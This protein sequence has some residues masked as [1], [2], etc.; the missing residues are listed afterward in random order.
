MAFNITD[1]ARITM[2]GQSVAPAIWSYG[3]ADTFAT[4]VASA[5]FNDVAANLNIGDWI[6]IKASDSNLAVGV[7]AVTPNVTVSVISNFGTAL[8]SGN[9]LVGNAGNIA[10]SV[11]MSGDATMDNAGALTVGK[12]L[13]GGNAAN[14]AV[15]SVLGA[16]PVLHAVAVTGGSTA[17]YNVT[18][19]NKT[20]VTDAWVQ[21]NGLGTASD[22]ITV[23]STASAITN[24]MDINVADTTIVRA[25]TIDDATAAIPAGGVLRVNQVDGGG[26]DCPACTVYVLGWHVA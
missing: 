25:G 1:F 15:N 4:A 17:S 19:T 3:T 12:T 9:I 5:Y 14:I 8:T 20:I 21:L 11:T 2:A 10:T 18:L 24:A 13:D 16:L 7:T 26:S 23:L 6:Y 22:T